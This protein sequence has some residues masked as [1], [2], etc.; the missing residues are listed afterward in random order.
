[1]LIQ[2][3]LQEGFKT[4]TFSLE[5]TILL[6]SQVLIFITCIMVEDQ[7]NSMRNS[8]VNLEKPILS[9]DLIQWSSKV[10]QEQLMMKNKFLMKNSAKTFKNQISNLEMIQTCI[11]QPT[12]QLVSQLKQEVINQLSLLTIEALKVHLT[13]EADDLQAKLSFKLRILKKIQTL[14]IQTKI[15][16]IRSRATILIFVKI[17]I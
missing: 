1:M 3:K 16:S 13:L 12:M 14:Q 11:I 5:M 10:S 15:S 4:Q 2:L 9:L 6:R 17:Q 8:L 7:R